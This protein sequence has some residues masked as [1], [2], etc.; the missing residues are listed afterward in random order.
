MSSNGKRLLRRLDYPPQVDSSEM[1][2]LN[3]ELDIIINQKFISLFYG[4]LGS[5]KMFF[6]FHANYL[7][8]HFL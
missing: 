4:T 2:L 3:Y 8:F 7:D 6:H 5:A 1:N